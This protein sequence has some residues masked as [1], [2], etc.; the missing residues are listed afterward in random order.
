[1][2]RPGPLHTVPHGACTT[3]SNGS[4]LKLSV[5]PRDRAGRSQYAGEPVRRLTA[6]NGIVCSTSRSGNVWVNAVME[7]FVSSLE[8]AQT[9]ASPTASPTSE[10]HTLSLGIDTFQLLAKT[11]A[12]PS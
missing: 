7:S 10:L 8:T 9:I 5:L 6:G 11:R 3:M 12:S 2:P 1:M 4:R